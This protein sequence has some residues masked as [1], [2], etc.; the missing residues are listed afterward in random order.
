[1][2]TLAGYDEPSKDLRVRRKTYWV[3]GVGGAVAAMAAIA[4]S[5][6]VSEGVVAATFLAAVVVYLIAFT[7][8]ALRLFFFV[9]PRC[10]Q[11][12]HSLFYRQFPGG[13]L[14]QRRCAHCGLS[15]RA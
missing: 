8:A 11:R 15:G 1:M 4:A 13:W 6:M 14:F 7:W 2:E 9:C 3:V 12:F 5:T 10:Y